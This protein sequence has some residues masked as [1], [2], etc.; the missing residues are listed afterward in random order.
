MEEI[1]KSYAIQRKR[2]GR[3]NYKLTLT[4]KL[5]ITLIY[6]RE[7][8]TM[9]AL[10]KDYNVSK[11][12]IWKAIRFAENILIKAEFLHIEGKKVLMNPEKEFEVVLIDVT[13]CEIE[14]PQEK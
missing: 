14:R 3:P 5:V 1:E 7:Y 12:E 4:D 9:N 6:L 10:S 13:E 2:W 11:N 8:R